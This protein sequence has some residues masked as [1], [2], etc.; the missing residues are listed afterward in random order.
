MAINP[1]IQTIEN[2]PEYESWATSGQMDRLIATLK[3]TGISQTDA[4]Q[5]TKLLDDIKDSGKIDTQVLRQVLGNLKTTVTL[6]R[7]Q[8]KAAEQQDKAERS[9]WQKSAQNA[10]AATRAFKNA[11]ITDAL[12]G[13]RDLGMIPIESLS[14]AFTKVTSIVSSFGKGIFGVA[15]SIISSLGK[16]GAGVGK[17]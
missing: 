7:D 13:T 1:K 2:G 8:N 17:Y 11:N 15:N 16:I 9:F 4:K 6:D 12:K 3:S 10:Q 14:D 5:L